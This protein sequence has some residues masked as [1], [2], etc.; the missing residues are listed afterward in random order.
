MYQKSESEKTVTALTARRGY[1]PMSIF[2]SSENILVRRNGHILLSDFGCS[3]QI[4]T[5]TG[6]N[7]IPSTTTAESRTREQS[8]SSRTIRP[9]RCSFVGTSFYVSPEV[10]LHNTGEK[11]N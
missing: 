9:R 7:L 10:L 3:K 2:L 6:Q 11:L 5:E 1:K 4:N 8:T